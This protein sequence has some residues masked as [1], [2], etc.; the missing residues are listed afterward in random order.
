M[1]LYDTNHAILEDE[2]DAGI[3]EFWWIRELV[4]I[5]PVFKC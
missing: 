1:D 5:F 4:H 2:E 3:D